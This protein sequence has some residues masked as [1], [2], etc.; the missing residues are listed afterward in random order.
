M[1]G[2]EPLVGLCFD[3]MVFDHMN[4][5][6]SKDHRGVMNMAEAEKAIG[7]N[8]GQI[9]RAIEE[10][11]VKGYVVVGKSHRRTWEN[12]FRLAESKS[13]YNEWREHILADIAALQEVL[14]SNDKAA[15]VRFGPMADQPKLF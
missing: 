13:E 1:D 14:A 12:D 11:R 8:D 2:K 6:Q 15:Q 7:L 5:V 4:D 9:R 3:R 10:I